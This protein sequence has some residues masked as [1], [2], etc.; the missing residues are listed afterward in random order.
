MGRSCFFPPRA[1]CLG[2]RRGVKP[3]P[4]RSTRG[5]PWLLPLPRFASKADLYSGAKGKGKRR[6]TKSLAVMLA[7]EILYISVSRKGSRELVSAAKFKAL[8]RAIQI[9]VGQ[10]QGVAEI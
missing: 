10:Q 8:V 1:L 7:Q 6:V 2:G 9:A 5:K 4:A 3:L